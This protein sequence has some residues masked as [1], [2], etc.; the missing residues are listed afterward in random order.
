[1]AEASEPGPT[2]PV[3]ASISP[4]VAR[5]IT[6][7]VTTATSADAAMNKVN[8]GHGATNVRYE[9]AASAQTVRRVSVH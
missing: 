3:I 1:M 6:V 9:K 7:G 8:G 5:T 2:D 4:L